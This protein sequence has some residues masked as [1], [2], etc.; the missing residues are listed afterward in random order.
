[1]FPDA[2]SVFLGRYLM[3]VLQENINARIA[4]ERM[5]YDSLGIV[6]G[7]LKGSELSRSTVDNEAFVLVY[8]FKRLG[9]SLSN[10]LD[11]VHDHWNLAYTV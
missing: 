1:M 4:V 3:R 9:Q 11:I 2:R 5:F 6:S 7:A 10:R 8:V